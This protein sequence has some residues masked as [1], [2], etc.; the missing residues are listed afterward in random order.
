M[1]ETVKTE[2]GERE[3]DK[4]LS[5]EES[6]QVLDGMAARLEDDD[7]TLDESFQI[8]QKGMKILADVNRKLDLYEKKMK[9]IAP[10]GT[11]ED[12]DQ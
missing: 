9:V 1:A 5:V 3:E 10:D 8:Y 2:Q 7:V 4:E 6:F 11:L 12:F